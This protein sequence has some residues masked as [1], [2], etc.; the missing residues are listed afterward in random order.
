MSLFVNQFSQKPKPLPKKT[1]TISLQVMFPGF[2]RGPEQFIVSSGKGRNVYVWAHLHTF[3]RVQCKDCGLCIF[4]P[5]THRE[6]CIYLPGQTTGWISTPLVLSSA[7][8]LV[9]RQ[10]LPPLFKVLSSFRAG[11]VCGRWKCLYLT[12]I[13]GMSFLTASILETIPWPWNGNKPLAETSDKGWTI[14][15]CMCVHVRIC[16]RLCVDLFECTCSCRPTCKCQYMCVCQCVMEDHRSYQAN[17]S[18]GPLARLSAS[19]W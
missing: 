13:I 19:P 5:W 8:H 9:L 18:V 16:E 17:T 4:I 6:Q 7:V 1:E 10:S 3:D 2:T 11:I 14:S 12:Q 15:H